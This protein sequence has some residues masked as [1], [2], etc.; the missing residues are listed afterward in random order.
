MLHYAYQTAQISSRRIS[1]EPE[2]ALKIYFIYEV[3]YFK[4][5]QN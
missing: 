5:S 2:T 4:F 1:Q 3:D